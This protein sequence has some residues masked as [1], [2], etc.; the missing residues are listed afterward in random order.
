MSMKSF[1]ASARSVGELDRVDLD[2]Q[3]LEEQWQRHGDV[4]LERFWQDRR[5]WQTG[6]T[7]DSQLV[8]LGALI[9]ADLRCRFDRGQNPEV[10]E[11]LA[12]FPELRQ[13]DSRVI[14]LIYEE[15]C[16][17]EERGESPR[18]EAFCE[19]YPKWKDSLVSQLAYHRL[20]SQAAGLRP[21]SPRFPDINSLF[22]EFQ[23]GEMIG[24]GGSSR[25][26]LARDLSLGGKRVVLK[27][28]LDRG[29]EP[30]TQGALD[31]PH[32]VPV[33]SVAFQPSQRLRGLSMPYRP[34][35]PL[36]EIVRRIGPQNRPASARAIWDA[37]FLDPSP[38]P[39][40]DLEDLGCLQQ[41]GP[42]GDGWKGFP[43]TG[44]YAQGVAWI[45]MILARTLHYAHGMQTFHRDVKP[46]N[47]LLTLQ[48]GPQLL[49]FNL[50]QS[51]HSVHHAESAMLGGTLPY[52][53]PEQI[54]AFLNPDLWGKVGARA[55]IYSLGLVLR[56]LLTGQAPD[57][58]DEKL[59]L[60]RAMQDLLD[61]SSRLEL[62][63]RRFNPEIPHALQS[64]VQACLSFRPDDRYP[65]AQ[66]LADDLGRFLARE[67]LRFA[68]NPS[69]KE[70]LNNVV[71]RH[72]RKT[73]VAALLILAGTV[74]GYLAQPSIKRWQREPL[75]K[76]PLFRQA[77]E[78]VD[79]GRYAKASR[80][81]R[82]LSADYSDH[83]VL[84]TY[85]AILASVSNEPGENDAQADLSKAFALPE[86]ESIVR[87]WA[88]T[89]PDFADQMGACVKSQMRTLSTFKKDPQNPNHG[90]IE[91]E[92]YQNMARAIAL[93]LQ[94]K[95]HDSELLQ[96]M[97]VVEE[98]FGDF[99]S[100]YTR[101]T[102]LNAR[103]PS[104]ESNLD[105]SHLLDRITQR[106]RVGIRWARAL[107]ESRTRSNDEKAG[108]LTRESADSFG[109][110][111][112]EILRLAGQPGLQGRGVLIVYNFFWVA[113]EAWLD[114]GD[115]ES[116][117]GRS[118][119]ARSDYR[120]AKQSFDRL[121]AISER[122]ALFPLSDVEGLR[123]RVY[124][125]LGVALTRK[126]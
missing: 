121:R 21:A 70:R 114:L 65:D 62:D 27:V 46:G 100:A 41:N 17:R 90:E 124:A 54:E 94:I 101:L 8:H 39:P 6:K 48:H 23:L 45:A 59:P 81:L 5:A 50:A 47:I 30:K 111:E 105:R 11:Y 3:L 89:R 34:G 77:V 52:M 107:R 9:K 1:L 125:A 85:L 112:S 102:E 95:P 104:E 28:S 110:Y 115:L 98:Y 109:Q 35:L 76:L 20:F 91:R 126:E 16:L 92:Y 40:S 26:F 18:V 10:G 113:T 29:E 57:L 123:K 99:E 116:G 86:A 25:V 97:A 96:E 44:S 66:T 79:G 68:V 67:P 12:T 108:K 71:I 32:I 49:D 80:A 56:E 120:Q 87:N 36:D 74:L 106:G 2:V 93:A 51:P 72:R 42:S 73:A 69:I 15:F 117:H 118:G 103:W 58:P 7:A 13:A 4:S 38:L 63:L 37:L 53:A 88:V 55:D 60:A 33:N 31:H 24:K 83:P 119:E 61:L 64:I 43:S 82:K 78:D 122:H 22:E 19:R 75:D 84:L 14:S